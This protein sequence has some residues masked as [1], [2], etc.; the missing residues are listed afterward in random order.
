MCRIHMVYRAHPYSSAHTEY[1]TYNV[2]STY[3]VHSAHNV[4]TVLVFYVTVNQEVSGILHETEGY[5]AQESS[6]LNHQRH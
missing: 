5:G 1:S 4:H 3:S 2:H 6:G